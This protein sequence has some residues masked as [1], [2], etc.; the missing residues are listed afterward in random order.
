M[1]PAR[2]A[3]RAICVLTFLC[4]AALVAL[5]IHVGYHVKLH[6]SA[7]MLGVLGGFVA[8]LSSLGFVGA[9]REKSG[10]LMLFFF[11][12]FLLLTCLLVASYGVICFRESIEAWVRHHW[13]HAV[14]AFMRTQPCCAT[15]DTMVQFMEARMMMLSAVGF[16]ALVL[17]LL[18]MYL[19]VRIVTVPIVMKHMLTVIN[20]IFFFAGASLLAYGAAVKY[21]EEPTA[22]QRWMPMVLLV[23]GSCLLGFATVG[24][25]GARAKSRTVL[26][27]Y[28][29]GIG[30]CL[31]ALLVCAVGA[32]A[33]S[34][35]LAD[36][37]ERDRAGEIACHAGLAGCTNCSDVPTEM[38]VCHGVMKDDEG[39][40]VPCDY[41]AV[42]FDTCKRGMTA[43][44]H[45]KEKHHGLPNQIAECGKC[46]EWT[47]EDVHEYIETGLH[48]MG[49]LTAVTALFIV[50][51]FVSA[52]VL[53]KSLAGYQTDSI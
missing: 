45:E 17:L 33:F 25:I 39:A 40:W 8:L 6:A 32:F 14:L 42:K 24:V 52:F 30:S 31:V 16:S 11:V 1:R 15:Y 12:N 48:V 3:L 41:H 28:L 9:G 7:V 21:K 13:D 22:G 44:F 29:F 50:V 5:S 47:S 38:L 23:T 18:S 4:G 10:M 43:L 46:P 19:V 36:H 35:S 51:G 20:V 34:N 37:Y 53:R 49:L 27:L 26:L 2:K